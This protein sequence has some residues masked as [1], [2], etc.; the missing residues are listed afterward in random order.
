MTEKT[1]QEGEWV[2]FC[3]IGTRNSLVG[4]VESVRGIKIIVKEPSSVWLHTNGIVFDKAHSIIPAFITAHITK[5]QAIDLLL[6][7]GIEI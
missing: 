2:L 3:D 4:M 6:M 1:P 7:R 5:E